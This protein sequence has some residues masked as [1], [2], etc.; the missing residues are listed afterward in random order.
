MKRRSKQQSPTEYGSAAA[1]AEAIFQVKVWL[2]GI[3]PMV[4]RRVL[5]PAEVT[6]RELHGVIQVVM[7][8]EGVHLYQFCLRAARYGSW[9]WRR[10]RPR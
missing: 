6:L 1:G 2:I 8:R 5:V 4:W 7:G 3:S 9:E 10:R